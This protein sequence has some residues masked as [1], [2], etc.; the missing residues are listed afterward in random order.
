[1][2]VF[3]LKTGQYEMFT[4]IPWR[5]AHVGISF[6]LPFLITGLIC[7]N[8][9]LCLFSVNMIWWWGDCSFLGSFA[10]VERVLI[11]VV[12]VWKMKKKKIFVSA[13]LFIGDSV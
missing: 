4:L 11:C 7:P 5:N 13:T 8:D 10:R 9:F 6:R 2:G 3:L 12:T 1:M